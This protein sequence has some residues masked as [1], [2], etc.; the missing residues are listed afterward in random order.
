MMIGVP[1]DTGNKQIKK[2]DERVNLLDHCHR[3][4]ATRC[5]LGTTGKRIGECS[6]G[7]AENG[8]EDRASM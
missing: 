6:Q 1:L 8:K 5:V 2:Q 4:I 3:T 7:K